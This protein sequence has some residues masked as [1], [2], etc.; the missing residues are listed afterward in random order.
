[1]RLTRRDLLQGSVAVAAL[2]AN[3]L[4]DCWG[5][6]TKIDRPLEWSGVNLAGAEFGNVPGR[7]NIDYIYPREGDVA[8]FSKLG[9]N[10]FR[11]PFRWE[12][13]QPSLEGE[14]AT[15]EMTQ[16]AHLVGEI[17]RRGHTAILDPH[18][19]AK[20]RIAADG[21]ANEHV[22]GSIAVPI[23]AFEDFWRR[24]ASAFKSND[25]VVFGLMNEPY[26]LSAAAWLE[27]ANR[28]IAAIRGSG[29]G[30]LMTVPG[31]NYTGAHSWLSSGND[32]FANVSD[33]ANRFAI[34]VHQYVDDNSSGTS[35]EATSGTCG[36][37][38]LRVFQK[39][40]RANKLKAFLGEFGAADNPAALNALAD[41]CQ[42]MSA[43]P[44]VWLGWTAWS[45]GPFWPPDYMFN[46]GPAPDGSLREPTRILSGYAEPTTPEF[47]TWPRAAFDF[48]LV[49]ERFFGCGDMA[50]ALVFGEA[51]K[52]R[53]SQPGVT[54][55]RGPLLELLQSPEFTLLV[56]TENFANTDAGGDIVSAAGVSILARTSNGGLRATTA[57]GVRTIREPFSNWQLRRRSAISLRR[58]TTSIAIAGTGC[59]SVAGAADIPPLDDLV[60]GSH[61]GSG[62]IVRIT[63]FSGFAEAAA[64]ERLVA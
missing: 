15:D 23:R 42:E 59:G 22:I 29:A 58:A 37:D 38:R 48:D 16:L 50:T 27:I 26:G 19:Y 51:R 44:D 39:W 52:A 28:A 24:L 21:W 1:M 6:E 2:S 30:N 35:P 49:R 64:L 11:V 57:S 34:E 56:E 46:L 25:R 14:F 47:W 36:S 8:Y 40:A 32:V 63:A 4:R 55:A 10:C 61:S 54:R 53:T 18:N 43:N 13:L 17:T 3:P 7:C 62:R 12:R 5:A 33:P 45:A 20:R 9:F 31:T 60:I 41:I